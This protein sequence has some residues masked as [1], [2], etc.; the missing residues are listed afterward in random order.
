MA[1]NVI[2]I[3][4]TD[5]QARAAVEALVLANFSRERIFMAPN[6]MI[7]GKGDMTDA[8]N[9]LSG[10]AGKIFMKIF[11]DTNDALR[12]AAVAEQGSLI[13]FEA[14]NMDDALKAAD[15][16]DA[17]GAIN[18]NERATL[19][20]DSWTRQDR[21]AGY[22]NPEIKVFPGVAEY[23]KLD[24]PIDQTTHTENR[25]ASSGDANVRSR[26]VDR[27][28]GDNVRVREGYTEVS[29]TKT[30]DVETSGDST[31]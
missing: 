10:K 7:K 22:G 15:L 18:V 16:L 6:D 23:D 8:K 5:H 19:L 27:P 4:E 28:A 1:Q 25:M 12:Y 2:G 17:S 14:D 31:L 29:P 26:I 9:T 3:F 11:P 24:E 30:S 13:I 21:T 20:E